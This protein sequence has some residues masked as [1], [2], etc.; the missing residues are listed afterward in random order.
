LIILATLLVLGLAVYALWPASQ[1]DTGVAAQEARAP[2]AG[3]GK[4]PEPAAAEAEPPDEARE[5]SQRAQQLGEARQSELRLLADSQAPFPHHVRMDD[6]KAA[7]WSEIQTNPPQFETPGD[8]A[9]DAEMA[10]RLYMYYGMCTMAPRTALQADQRLERIASRARGVRGRYL[11]GLEF[12]ADQTIDMYELCLPIPLDVDPRAEAVV[13]MTEAV[14]LGH[15]I[16]QVQYY[17]KIMG[18]LL[19]T[20]PYLGGP[21][22]VMQNPELIWKFRATATRALEGA[23][24]NGHPEAWLAMSRAVSDGVVFP[25]DLVLALA[26]ARVAE[27]EAMQN[28]I[29]LNDLEEQKFAAGQFLDPAQRAEAEELAH[30]LRAGDG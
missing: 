21:P 11:E 30:R 20:D 3:D 14:R 26:Y 19:R 23:L 9:V 24:E 5:L 13:W 7:L 1:S 16:A 8:P 27:L 25:K 22:L 10:Y 2:A 6:Y 17:D 28:R 15:E 29:L 12:R 4:N 18:F